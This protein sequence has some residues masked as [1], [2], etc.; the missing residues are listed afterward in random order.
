MVAE[1]TMFHVEHTPHGRGAGAAGGARGGSRQGGAAAGARSPRALAMSRRM[2]RGSVPEGDRAEAAAPPCLLLRGDGSKRPS[3]PHV[4]ETVAEAAGGGRQRP[5]ATTAC[6]EKG[7]AA[8][9]KNPCERGDGERRGGRTAERR[10]NGGNGA[11]DRACKSPPA[12][13]PSPP[14]T[15]GG[16]RGEK[17]GGGLQAMEKRR[18]WREPGA[19]ED[20]QSGE[21]RRRTS[22]PRAPPAAPA[23]RTNLSY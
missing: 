15:G 13:E 4:V 11:H 6:G 18:D 12:P 2:P 14:I 7:W 21:R 17:A 9:W 3:P 20:N 16:R 5:R 8:C 1:A 19:T 10:A 22:T 23:P